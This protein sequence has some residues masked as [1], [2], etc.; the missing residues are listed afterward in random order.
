MGQKTEEFSQPLLKF[1]SVA[2]VLFHLYTA[3]N[4][5]FRAFIQG[6]VHLGFAIIIIFLA[7]P[8][9]IRGKKNILTKTVNWM[10]II[11]AF[12]FNFRIIA[13]MGEIPPWVSFNLSKLDFILAL[14]AISVT[15]EATRRCTGLAMPLV[16]IFFLAYAFTGPFLPGIFAHP[17]LSL[18]RV[19]STSYLTVQGIYGVP[20]GIS[21]VD[22]FI[23]VAYGGF[24]FN[25]GGGEFIMNFSK[26]LVGGMVGGIAKIAV[27]ASAFFGTISGSGPANAASTGNFTIPTMIG[28][29]Y[30][31][32]FAA[33]VESAASVG[34]QIMP[35]VMG[36]ASF[37][38]AEYLGVPY[39]K[40]MLAALFPSLLY[41]FGI[42]IAVDCQARLLGLNPLPRKEIPLA[43]D[44]FRGS[45]HII[46]SMVVLVY[47]LL[48]EQ[49]GPSASGFWAIVSLV[50][51]FIIE[52]AVI[53]RQFDIV[54]LLKRI[55]DGC[56]QGA[57]SGSLIAVASAAAG[58]ILGIVDLSGL[59][60]KFTS[61]LVSMSA[62]N[63]ALLLVLTMLASIVLGM[64]LPTVACYILV[65]AL[66]VP[67]LIKAG[68]LPIAAHMFS[69]YFA[70]MSN[71]T[72]PVALTAYVAAGIANANPIRTAF[73]GSRLGLMG[74]ALPFV[75]IVRPG[76]LLEGSTF[77]IFYGIMI[78]VIAVSVVTFSLSGFFIRR[79]LLHERVLLFIGGVSLL[80]PAYYMDMIGILTSSAALLIIIKNKSRLAES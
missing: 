55:L 31:R 66:A 76:L 4:I 16:I 34:G 21:S 10:L 56:L 67:A 37:I 72:P 60:I 45:S 27:V 63:I 71:L 42:F 15:I 25:L 24:M 74:F 36:A 77:D 61:S 9:T 19:L 64:G 79:L 26:F 44:V 33:A 3:A 12:A 5:P 28:M 20:I 65:A 18:Q 17:G 35:P 40:I 62:G 53:K 32:E 30:Q 69:F 51:A 38:M 23:L 70:I 50:I 57:A 68:I 75:F 11:A 54:N 78:A 1:A 41:Y 29:G 73:I 8:F 46:I 48:V 49:F 47:L 14:L 43:K 2:M 6:A 52:E 59:A 58:I 13:A 80:Y 39:S 22:I 7:T